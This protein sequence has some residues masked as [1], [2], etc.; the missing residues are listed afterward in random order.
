MRR[1][2]D[3]RLTA[4]GVAGFLAGAG[5]YWVASHAAL[6]KP[7]IPTPPVALLLGWSLIGSGLL[8]ARSRREDHLALALIFTGF[9]WFAS[10]LPLS[11]IDPW[12]LHRI[13]GI[14]AVW[15]PIAADRR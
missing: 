5:A 7:E 14:L 4:L 9:A 12:F 6:H 11:H 1:E 2:M 3:T 13:A 10:M 15:A 8:A